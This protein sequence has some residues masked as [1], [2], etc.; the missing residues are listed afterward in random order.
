M[1]AE[2]I[3]FVPRPDPKRPTLTET[4]ELQAAEFL[5]RSQA[6]IGTDCGNLGGSWK[7]DSA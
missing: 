7:D 2:I 6:L 1:S 3:Q 4:E 5:L